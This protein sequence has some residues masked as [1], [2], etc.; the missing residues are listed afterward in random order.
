MSEITNITDDYLSFVNNCE[1]GVLR[2]QWTA[3]QKYLKKHIDIFW[4]KGTEIFHYTDLVGLIGILS[5]KG[6]WI[7]DVRFL[8]DSEEIINGVNLSIEIIKK[9][10]TKNK[11]KP[12]QKILEGT[13]HELTSGAYDNQYI[14][15]FST[16]CDTLEHWRAYA[17]NG[18]GICIG[19]DLKKNT[20]YPHFMI[21]NQYSLQKVI[22]DDNQKKWILISIIRKYFNEFMR[23]INKHSHDYSEDY[24]ESMTNSLSHVF[25]NFK[26]KSFGS[27]Q[28][29]RLV[30]SS[31]RV[32]FYKK[33]VFR[34]S[35][36]MIVPYYCTYETK[37]ANSSG[38]IIEPDKLPVSQIIIGPV[39]SQDATISSIREFI[40]SLGYDEQVPIIKSRVPYR[41]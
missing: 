5:N 21:G 2:A 19:F 3:Q 32:D 29:V 24:I 39:A 11:Y 15:C 28:E 31:K 41:G 33:K 4:Y 25:V 37:L 20:D 35:N 16:G 10:F 38:Q 40:G 34:V 14:C 13:I 12:F 18:S 6:F 1:F 30:N 22:Y 8:N 26:N 17:K 7:S 9:M 23:D 36:N 27:E